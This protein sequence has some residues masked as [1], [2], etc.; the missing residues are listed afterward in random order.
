VVINA[1]ETL[2]GNGVTGQ[3]GGKTRELPPTGKTT[4]NGGYTRLNETPHMDAHA[5]TPMQTNI[6]FPHATQF[7]RIK[8]GC[9]N[10][11]RNN[12]KTDTTKRRQKDNRPKTNK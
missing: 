4:R 2:K 8:R 12:E 6:S 10:E 3:E 11:R 9:K 1:E 7:G 5:N